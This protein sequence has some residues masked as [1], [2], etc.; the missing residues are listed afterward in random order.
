M[1]VWSQAVYLMLKRY[2]ENHD[3]EIVDTHYM[4]EVSSETISDRLR[5][6]D[7]IPRWQP[8]VMVPGLHLINFAERCRGKS[9]ALLVLARKQAT[10]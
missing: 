9:D 3:F 8:S 4:L 1:E 7:T 6:D 5:V 10:R 2:L